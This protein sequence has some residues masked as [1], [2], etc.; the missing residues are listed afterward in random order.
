MQLPASASR[1]PCA[2]RDG[3]PYRPDRLRS[4]SL[5]PP[6]LALS[7]IPQALGARHGHR[8]LWLLASSA[9]QPLL[10]PLQ[11]PSIGSSYPSRLRNCRH[12]LCPRPTRRRGSR[13]SSSPCDL[14]RRYVLMF[15]RLPGSSRQ[16]GWPSFLHPAYP[17]SCPLSALSWLAA[18]SPHRPHSLHFTSRGSSTRRCSLPRPPYSRRCHHPLPISSPLLTRRP[19]L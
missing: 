4:S 14:L 18:D 19:V 12:G 1:A 15:P 9:F 5:G 17:L 16:P 11:E 13:A 10:L 8:L 3:Y 6:L 7:P 2:L